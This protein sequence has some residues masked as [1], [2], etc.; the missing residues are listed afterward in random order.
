MI[1]KQNWKNRSPEFRKQVLLNKANK[2]WRRNH[3]RK[4][5]HS[6]IS[7]E[8]KEQ[9][10][11]AILKR[12]F[13]DYRFITAPYNFSLSDNEERALIFLRKIKTSYDY[14]EKVLVRLDKVKSISNDAILLLMS[15]MVQFFT[16]GIKFNGTKPYKKSVKKK[17]EK[18]GFY[19]YLTGQTF[20]IRDQYSF[21]N[22]ESML[23]THGQKR[24]DPNLANDIV[25]YSSTFVWGNPRRCQGVQKTLLELMHN[26]YDHADR[27][28]GEKHWWLSVEQDKDKREVTIAFIDFGV[29]IFRSL[30]NKKADEPLYGALENLISRFPGVRTE[31]EILRLI[32]EGKIRRTQSRK[33]NRGKGLSKIHTLYKENK[34]SSLVMVSNNAFA[35]LDNDDFHELTDEFMGTFISFKINQNTVSLP[36]IA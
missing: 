5:K 1:Y 22:M 32:L 10:R 6:R 7:Q 35:H 26:T 30:K 25:R 36:W 2:R 16:A 8:V 31:S 21:N 33:Y 20:A 12:T 27:H 28:K 15:T 17:I 4:N 23:Y 3:R 14:G 13:S 9:I 29:G 24:V 11:A 18:S 34:I 19:N